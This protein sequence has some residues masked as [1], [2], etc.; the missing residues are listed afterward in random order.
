MLL[1]SVCLY[2]REIVGEGKEVTLPDFKPVKLSFQ[3]LMPLFYARHFEKFRVLQKNLGSIPKV[4][5]DSPSQRP[6]YQ[7]FLTID[8]ILRTKNDY[9]NRTKH[10]N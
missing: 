1:T 6:W 7:N 2:E 9:Q 3:T 5:L 10:N 4:L 8:E